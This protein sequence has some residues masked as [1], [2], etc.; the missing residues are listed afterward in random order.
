MFI[1]IQQQPKNKTSFHVFFRQPIA[2][3]V[4]CVVCPVK[5]KLNWIKKKHVGF[6]LLDYLFVYP[7][8]EE[9][10]K[11]GCCCVYT[12]LHFCSCLGDTHTRN[13]LYTHTLENLPYPQVRLCLLFF[14]PPKLK[15]IFGHLFF[16]SLH[17]FKIKGGGQK[18]K[19][20]C[21]PK[22]L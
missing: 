21:P 20:G 5:F 14:D 6:H 9:V 3:C 10:K 8:K 12:L 11:S 17:F 7:E 22:C 1:R 2:D 19:N 15:N 18:K 16:P 13:N 4:C